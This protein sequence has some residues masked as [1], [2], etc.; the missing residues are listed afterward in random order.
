MKLCTLLFK[1]QYS[2]RL[3]KTTTTAEYERQLRPWPSFS[4]FCY[5]WHSKH[6][7]LLAIRCQHPFLTPINNC[8]F[9]SLSMAGL[10]YVFTFGTC[11]VNLLE[12][13]KPAFS[14]SLDVELQE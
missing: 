13:H 6:E 2:K 10:D 9:G 1:K 5:A 11:T 14:G 3:K 8:I 7:E 12:K 4:S